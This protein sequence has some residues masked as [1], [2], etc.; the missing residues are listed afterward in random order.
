MLTESIYG[1]DI[2]EDVI[3]L[4]IFSLSLAM[5]DEVDLTL[6]TWDSLKFQDL[7][8]NIIFE[9]FFIYISG[10]HD[11]DY[12]LIIGN[13]PFNIPLENRDGKWKEPKRKEYFTRLK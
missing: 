11:S 8:N 4:S 10:Q 1:I 12:Y 3:N 7:S 2:Q 5:L 9:N 6:P 13:P